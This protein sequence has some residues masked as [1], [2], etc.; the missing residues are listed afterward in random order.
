MCAA[1]H[2]TLQFTR[3]VPGTTQVSHA[4]PHVW[5]IL[6]SLN[7]PKYLNGNKYY[8]LQLP[9]LRITFILAI[10]FNKPFNAQFCKLSTLTD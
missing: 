3:I 7:A 2:L 10:L 9:T 8:F 4:H 6:A 5:D 1:L